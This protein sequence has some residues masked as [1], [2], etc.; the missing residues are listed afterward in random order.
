MNNQLTTQPQNA[1]AAFSKMLNAD[2]VKRQFTNAL[3]KHTDNFT[4]SLIEQ[5][6]T[7]KQLQ[8]CPPALVITEALKAAVLN[9]PLNNALGQGYVICFQNSIKTQNAQ[10]GRDEWVKQ[11]TP[12][13]VI[14]YKGMIQLA[15]RT[16]QYKIINADVVYEGEMVRKDKLTGEVTFDTDKRSSDKVVG[17][18]CYFELLNG[19][20][21][22]LYM[23]VE[24][25]AA[26]AM[27][28]APAVKGNRNITKEQLI[29]KAETQQLGTQVGWIGNFTDMALKTVT[30]RLLSKYGYLSTEMQTAIVQ[31]AKA[32]DMQ[33]RNE[34]VE[35]N[36]NAEV[37]DANFEEINTTEE[38]ATEEKLP[39]FPEMK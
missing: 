37:I 15:M 31:D 24:E 19:F 25:M 21:K 32:D 12:T 20:R 8:Q 27:R 26:Y 34:E 2:S 3:G 14:G 10:T 18:F 39:T 36:A 17:Y 11:M 22:M 9:L 38:K 1:V 13:F 30:R 28:Y 23:S 35:T 29:E 6:T 7:N 16:G 4:A 5:Y 33:T